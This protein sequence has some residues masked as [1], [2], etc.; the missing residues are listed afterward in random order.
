MKKQAKS[1]MKMKFLLP[2]GFLVLFFFLIL[3]VIFSL[4]LI[5]SSD[6]GE[7]GE[8]IGGDGNALV[9]ENIER[10]RP[11]FEKY[12]K[13]HGIP[14]QVELL[15]A[16]AMQESGGRHLDV[17]QSSESIGLPPNGIIRPER[18][19]D[20]GV[21]YFSQMLQQANGDTKL[22]LQAYNFGG[23]FIDYAM[24]NGGK[25]TLEV[26]EA[27][28]SMQAD[29]LGWESYGDTSYLSNVMRYMSGINTNPEFDG[30]WAYPVKNPV[31]TSEYGMR[32][33]PF[34]GE[35]TMH[36]G[37]DFDCDISDSIYSV[38]DGTVE[39][40]VNFHVSYGNYVMVKHND[41]DY[42]LYA[43][44]SSLN[45][46]EGDEVK[47]GQQLGVCGTTG[48]STG[49]H[50]HLEYLVDGQKKDPALKLNSEDD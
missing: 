17:M 26:A 36:S 23:G 35:Q 45:V 48:N 16:I 6:K 28:S 47:V 46:N 40:A 49:T 33:D 32:S 38:G 21:K 34:T 18:S 39:Q 15:M 12:A 7:S 22:A 10:M 24:N 50:L 30:E 4:L 41:N 19:I 29:K 3:G 11:L 25:Y 5:L 37:L 20:V 31:I 1:L 44:M 8:G 13:L 2:I 43:H 42:S 14:E 27:F 9:N